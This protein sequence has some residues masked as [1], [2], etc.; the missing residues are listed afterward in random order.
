MLNTNTSDESTDP[1]RDWG[2]SGSHSFMQ[3]QPVCVCV[4]AGRMRCVCAILGFFPRTRAQAYW[5]LPHTHLEVR[6]DESQPRAGKLFQ[7]VRSVWQNAQLYKEKV[8]GQKVNYWKSVSN[9]QKNRKKW[10]K[11]NEEKTL[12]WKSWVRTWYFHCFPCLGLLLVRD[13]FSFYWVATGLQKD[14]S[15]DVLKSVHSPD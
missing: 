12:P 5:W 9:R 14:C 1:L 13:H 11:R 15:R 10:L 6:F 7:M 3:L 8:R 4:R 2:E